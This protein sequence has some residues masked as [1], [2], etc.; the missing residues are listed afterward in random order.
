[1]L[2]LG[3]SQEMLTQV[4]NQPHQGVASDGLDRMIVV[5]WLNP[6]GAILVDSKVTKYT[7]VPDSDFRKIEEVT[8]HL[9][10]RISNMLP[11]GRI[12]HQSPILELLPIVAESF[13]A[14]VT[15]HPDE[16]A[17][18]VYEGRWDGHSIHVLAY[19]T[20][21]TLF[22]AGSFPAP[23]KCELAWS[24]DRQRYL[25]WFNKHLASSVRTSLSI[26]ALQA[27]ITAQRT[28]LEELFPAGWFADEIRG[29]SHHPANIRWRACQDLL[30]QSGRVRIADDVE[31]VKSFLATW[32]DNVALIQAT[33]GSVVS[34]R[35]GDL[36]NYGDE[37]V[38]NRLR[39]VVLDPDQFFDVLLEVSCAAWH[40][41]HGHKVQATERDGMPDFAL[42]IPGW[43]LP[44]QAE[45]KRIRRGPRV[46][47]AIEK[48]NRQIKNVG[49]RCYGLVYLDVSECAK[50]P[51]LVDPVSLKADTLPDEIVALK[52]EVQRF[53]DRVY[54]SLSG[55][56]L[57][58]KHQTVLPM[59]DGGLLFVFRYQNLLVRH[60]NPKEPLPEDTEQISVG[61]SNTV[62]I[63][64]GA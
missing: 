26:P 1:M 61:F 5:H 58:W 38:Q 59:N 33:Q 32:L 30:A 10:I 49:Q 31:L 4:V 2:Q 19:S 44:I 53:L 56:I 20:E 48:A 47:R 15:G 62:R 6:E 23:G 29:R 17:A 64:P 37:A 51:D 63:L 8:P 7:D 12:H 55:V 52:N 9:A 25:G 11:A 21:S 40:I 50:V 16:D 27:L 28:L 34:Q 42:E 36:A 22:V 3:I 39:T 54:T 45:C 57:L 14:K 41:S 18:W 43:Q 24:L 13:G 46:K 35:L 60:R